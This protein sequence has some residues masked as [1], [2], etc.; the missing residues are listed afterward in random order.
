MKTLQ[1]L[2]PIEIES[3]RFKL[4][5]ILLAGTVSFQNILDFYDLIEKYNLRDRFSLS[6][7]SAEEHINNFQ[8][9]FDNLTA[10]YDF[11]LNIYYGNKCYDKIYE[12][13]TAYIFN[14]LN[15]YGTQELSSAYGASIDFNIKL[16]K[17]K[18]ISKFIDK[19][20]DMLKYTNEKLD[21]YQGQKQ[22]KDTKYKAYMDS[23]LEFLITPYYNKFMKK[24]KYYDFIQ[25]S[26]NKLTITN[27]ESEYKDLPEPELKKLI[28]D[29]LINKN[30]KDTEQSLR[31]YNIN[32][33]KIKEQLDIIYK[34]Y[35]EYTM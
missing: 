26:P 6:C 32:K 16:S 31:L 7:T 20:N 25:F 15:Q 17:S 27:L 30:F 35:L 29:E 1:N 28:V 9:Q 19:L 12:R 4:Q 24:S 5:K 13:K 2:I 10:I 33:S 34:D 14:Y 3:D 8:I 23:N 11:D 22:E 21:Y 18:F